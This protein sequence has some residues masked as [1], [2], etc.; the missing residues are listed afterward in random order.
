[1][2]VNEDMLLEVQNNI[3]VLYL[4]IKRTTLLIFCLL[5]KVSLLFPKIDYKEE[6]TSI[7]NIKSPQT[8]KFPDSL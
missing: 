2:S 6:K 7:I 3:S 1:M 8:L 5:T 4:F